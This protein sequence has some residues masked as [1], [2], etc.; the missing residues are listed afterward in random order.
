MAAV[1]R[2][3]QQGAHH[4]ARE[5]PATAGAGR[6]GHCRRSVVENPA[7]QLRGTV[8]RGRQLPARR[9]V[10]PVSRLPHGRKHRRVEI[11]RRTA[12]RRAEGACQ[13][14]ETGL[15]DAGH[16]RDTVLEDHGDHHRLDTESHRQGQN[17]GAPRGGPHGCQGGDTG[18]AGPRRVVGQDAG[19][20]V[21]LLGLRNQHIAQLLRHRGQQAAVPHRQRRAAPL[22]RPH[23]G[24]H[25]AGAGNPQGRTAG[26][27]ALV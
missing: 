21:C 11:Q 9:G 7:P 1:I 18:A 13:N 2:R 12:R 26:T 22:G 3:P 14:R 19:R 15:E 10:P 6:R 24:P 25:P 4:T 8:R 5:V 17:Q 16:P 27:A 23:Q 20:A